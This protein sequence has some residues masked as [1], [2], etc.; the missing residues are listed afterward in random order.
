MRRRRR[1]RLGLTLAVA[2]VAAASLGVLALSLGLQPVEP[3]AAPV[4]VTDRASYL[5]VVSG[6]T[7]GQVRRVLGGPPAEVETSPLQSEPRE[8]WVYD[9]RSGREGRYRFCF[10][11][12]V[13]EAKARD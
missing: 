7:R 10:R 13:L 12:A 2:A 1:R 6:S 11:G 8:C 4:G 5:Q 9:R 3:R